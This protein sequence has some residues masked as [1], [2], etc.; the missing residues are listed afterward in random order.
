MLLFSCK[1]EPKQQEVLTEDPQKDVASDKKTESEVV[2]KD[3]T[4]NSSNDNLLGFYVGS[5]NATDYDSDD[6]YM[7]KGS[8]H[9]KINI[10]VDA[11]K[12]DS[13]FGHSVV[14]GNSR[15][16]KGTFDK[17]TLQAFV[18]EPGND[19]YDGVFEF[20]FD[21]KKKIIKGIWLANDKNLAV[22]KR[23][24]N[25]NL[26]VYKYDP[27]LNLHDYEY[28][29]N[30]PLYDSQDERDTGSKMEA[31]DDDLIR[32]LNASTQT[33][34]NQDIENLNKGEL[35]VLRNLIYARHGYSF[36]NRKMRYFFDTQIDW[37]IPVSTDI[38]SQLTNL[39]KKN[40]DLI[41]RYEQHAERYYDYFGR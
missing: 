41:K 20:T 26:R 40:I 21:P 7:K 2:D 11:I 12:N 15:L 14:A 31:I 33:L 17:E 37:Y 4:N 25:L 27:N 22:P 30:I 28:D 24:Y 5:F 10:S 38:R 3:I 9:N 16:F 23:K 32:K 6:I 13:L 35:E 1:Q 29:S 18:S 8:Y 36:K 39:E 19:K 34:T